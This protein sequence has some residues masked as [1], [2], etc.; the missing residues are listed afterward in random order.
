MEKETRLTDWKNLIPSSK[1]SYNYGNSY[2]EEPKEIIKPP[3][4]ELGIQIIKNDLLQYHNRIVELI[5]LQ[6]ALVCHINKLDFNIMTLP[7]S[8]PNESDSG[9]YHGSV[10]EPD[11]NA[12]YY[13]N[14]RDIFIILKNH[15]EY[16]VT[17][18]SHINNCF[19]SKNFQSSTMDT[20][21]DDEQNNNTSSFGMPYIC[22]IT[23][24]RLFNPYNN[25][26]TQTTSFLLEAFHFHIEEFKAISSSSGLTNTNISNDS[27]LQQMRYLMS[28]SSIDQK[29]I[30]A[31]LLFI[32]DFDTALNWNPLGQP[33]PL[34]LTASNPIIT[35]T[36]AQ[37]HNNNSE[38]GVE[39]NSGSNSPSQIPPTESVFVCSLK[40]YALRHDI[41]SYFLRILAPQLT[42]IKIIQTSNL[43]VF[44]PA[45]HH[46]Q[47]RQQRQQSSVY[48]FHHSRQKNT[49]TPSSGFVDVDDPRNALNIHT[50]A[51]I[52]L[53][54]L[55]QTANRILNC[56][57]HASSE[58]ALPAPV[59]S[60]CRVINDMAGSE[61]VL[62]YYF[63]LF[64]LP[65]LIKFIIYDT[66]ATSTAASDNINDNNSYVNNVDFNN[67]NPIL[68]ESET[69][70][71]N[72]Y[73]F[74]E[75]YDK[76]YNIDAWWPNEGYSP[77]N[78]SNTSALIWLVWRL[79]SIAAA[80]DEVILEAL[81]T[82]DFFVNG[83]F[84]NILN[85]NNAATTTNV[86]NNS[87]LNNINANNSSN[88]SLEGFSN[89]KVKIAIYRLKK[90]IQK[91]VTLIPNLPLDTYANALLNNNNIQCVTNIMDITAKLDPISGRIVHMMP[92]K[93][94]K[95]TYGITQVELKK[96]LKTRLINLQILPSEMTSTVII[97]KY[98]LL[99]LL[100]DIS[101]TLES[102]HQYKRSHLYALI[103]TVF[104]IM[105]TDIE[106]INMAK[107]SILVIKLP[108]LSSDNNNN[109]NKSSVATAHGSVDTSR[110]DIPL[111][112]L[113]ALNEYNDM[114]QLFTPYSNNNTAIDNTNTKTNIN[115]NYFPQDFISNSITIT[116]T[117]NNNNM[118]DASLQLFYNYSQYWHGL[119]ISQLYEFLLVT[120]LNSS[121]FIELLGGP[122]HELHS[123]AAETTGTAATGTGSV[124][125][126]VYTSTYFENL[127]QGQITGQSR[128]KNDISSLSK[129]HTQSSLLKMKTPSYGLQPSAV[130]LSSKTSHNNMNNNNS[131]M[132]EKERHESAT[133]TYNSKY[134]YKI[135]NTTTYTNNDDDDNQYNDGTSIN[136][137][138]NSS[139]YYKPR[140]IGYSSMSA[141]GTSVTNASYLNS[142]VASKHRQYSKIIA[143]H[144]PFLESPVV[145]PADN[146][147]NNIN[148]THKPIYSTPYTTTSNHI[149]H[150]NTNNNNNKSLSVA[151]LEKMTD[152][153]RE[154]SFMKSLRTHTII[155]TQDF[156]IK[157]QK[158]YQKL[159]AAILEQQ[160]L[161]QHLHNYA[162]T[163]DTNSNPDNNT[164]ITNQ[165]ESYTYNNGT[166]L[167]SSKKVLLNANSLKENSAKYIFPS[168]MRVN[169]DDNNDDEEEEVKEV[170][171]NKLQPK[172]TYKPLRK[173]SMDSDNNYGNSANMN[174]SPVLKLLKKSKNT[175]HSRRSKS[176]SAATATTS[177][178]QQQQ[179]KRSG[180][181]SSPRGSS[182]G[183]GSGSIASRPAFKPAGQKIHPPVGHRAKYD[184]TGKYW[185]TIDDLP[186]DT[187]VNVE[188]ED[189]LTR[190]T[191]MNRSDG[192]TLTMTMTQPTR[193]RSTSFGG[194]HSHSHSHS[195]ISR[196]TVDIQAA[197]KVLTH[198]R[199]DCDDV[200]NLSPLDN[201]SRR[202][203]F[204]EFAQ[205]ELKLTGSTSTNPLTTHQKILLAGGT[206][207]SSSNNKS[208]SGSSRNGST[209]RSRSPSHDAGSVRSIGSKDSGKRS[210]SP[211]LQSS[212]RGGRESL[213]S[214][215]TG[216]GKD[217]IRSLTTGGGK[218]SFR[219]HLHN[220]NTK[221]QMASF[222]QDEIDQLLNNSDNNKSDTNH[223]K[224]NDT[225]ELISS[226]PLSN[227]PWQSTPTQPV[228][229]GSTTSRSSVPAPAAGTSCQSSVPES[230]DVRKAALSSGGLSE[231]E[232]TSESYK[233]KKKNTNNFITAMKKGIKI[234]KVGQ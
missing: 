15:P 156:L 197:D 108:R 189:V 44:Q 47:Q 158:L 142:T 102:T 34:L 226:T 219:S 96:I 57:F 159:R 6:R 35:S 38:K 155:P 232:T 141:A 206:S 183:S 19:I 177:V 13:E 200:Y 222:T 163:T 161:K 208:R 172:S 12:K 139:S 7:V 122:E 214:T 46:Q 36:C 190:N 68:T 195:P 136:G 193:S 150:N 26:Q 70:F 11:N 29:L 91:F 18:M 116:T 212:T 75:Y 89:H 230:S 76:Y 114:A 202:N 2:T 171:N 49:N 140:S 129:F 84:M 167:T 61:G 16:I 27:K 128:D 157:K 111:N 187:M 180:P 4:T 79:F 41:Y 30:Y 203:S 132:A 181:R 115:S 223:N 185:S 62:N 146:I 87:N 85:T 95:N 145:L 216:G 22:F 234:T 194:G 228:R 186:L 17:T 78:Y 21:N 135:N 182:G 72:K 131:M 123:L 217:S 170:L 50:V 119:C 39:S 65:N 37:I 164:V 66:E 43:P 3:V 9:G 178:S 73:E 125:Q 169:I 152:V 198:R 40:I 213:R 71:R 20:N 105:N 74:Y 33:L 31:R 174:L 184:A 199:Y 120:L 211:L 148:T 160:Q 153:E 231:L 133:S 63:N 207:N 151:V 168:S 56:L 24:H 109:D 134:R 233:Y 143:L 60:M 99:N 67:N 229:H 166:K 137:S 112:K 218:E 81:T 205:E 130:S 221:N 192:S 25:D 69:P 90:R 10:I 124:I 147:N 93:P 80:V 188:D 106:N 1:G 42:V 54:N 179:S 225:L 94:D 165:D 88:I 53:F 162:H 224:N 113:Y 98:E 126:T 210:K 209:S 204:K 201:R 220:N 107:E 64:V 52:T 86:N 191:E 82:Q 8:L 110:N 154:K 28:L 5:S 127:E 51:D 227:I 175:S 59:T 58:F 103:Y 117:T 118:D 144:N 101:I 83:P 97:S 45:A 138:V 149:I 176:P 77:D 55:F 215:S 32:N 121:P 92:D 100:D 14:L 104:E 173:P 48:N 23:L 196:L